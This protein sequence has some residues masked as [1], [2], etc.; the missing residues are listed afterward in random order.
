MPEDRTAQMFGGHGNNIWLEKDVRQNATLVMIMP[1][2]SL[3]C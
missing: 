3:R 2:K 1:Y